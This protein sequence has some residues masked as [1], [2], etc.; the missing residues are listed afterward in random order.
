M[1]IFKGAGVALVTPM[2]PNEEVNYSK[3]EELIE[4]Q[5]NNKTDALIIC[6]TTGEASTLSHD[7]HIEVVRY[8]VEKTAK[9]VPV[10]AG[11]GSN[12]TKTAIELSQRA[13]AAGA[14]GLLIVSPYYNKTTQKGLIEHYTSVANAVQLPIIV[15]NIPGRTGLN[16][17]P[18]TMAY[19]ANHVENIVGVKDAADNIS[20]TAKLMSLVGDDFSLYSGNDDQVLAMMVLGGSGVISTLS[21]IAPETMHN[22]TAEFFAGNIKEATRIQLNALNIIN[23]IFCEVNPIPVKTALN[24]I[25]MDVGPARPPLYEMEPEN[26]KRLEDEL[27][28]FG[29]I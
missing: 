24:I 2:L 3:L 4:F 9:R 28:K 20:Q 21:N 29:L 19:L 18:E 23:A 14:D 25:G 17:F 12:S 22:I 15:Y 7:E 27:R 13:E 5:I 11:T 10:I 8:A 1:A 6:G 16:I 26:K